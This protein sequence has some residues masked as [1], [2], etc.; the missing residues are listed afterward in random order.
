M[1]A[2]T[3]YTPNQDIMCQSVRVHCNPFGTKHKILYH[4]RYGQH[5]SL[6]FTPFGGLFYSFFSF[7]TRCSY[8]LLSLKIKKCLLNPLRTCYLLVSSYDSFAI[9]AIAF[10]QYFLF[11]QS[12]PLKN[13]GVVL[14]VHFLLYILN[15]K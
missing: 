7:F 13:S 9:F 3:C 4:I 6:L 1:K 15:P 14:L 10:E 5:A 2:C 11:L 12:K 8:C